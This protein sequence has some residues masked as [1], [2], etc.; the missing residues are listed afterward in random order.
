MPFSPRLRN[1]SLRLACPPD[2]L[3]QSPHLHHG[4]MSSRRGVSHTFSRTS[5]RPISPL[6]SANGSRFTQFPDATSGDR[7]LPAQTPALGG[8]GSSSRAITC[9]VGSSR[10]CPAATPVPPPGPALISSRHRWRH[11]RASLLP[12]S[13]GVPTVPLSN[14]VISRHAWEAPEAVECSQRPLR[15]RWTMK[16]PLGPD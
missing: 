16:N 3:S 9:T 6:P 7:V 12:R 1:G 11:R 8:R 14:S 10:E 2:T 4:P 13:A 5:S 15:F